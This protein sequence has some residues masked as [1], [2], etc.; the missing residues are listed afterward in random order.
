MQL[1]TLSAPRE[2]IK[3]DVFCVLKQAVYEAV[4]AAHT[5]VIVGM[6]PGV[7]WPVRSQNR[8]NV[9]KSLHS[10]VRLLENAG[11]LLQSSRDSA[12]L[13]CIFCSTSTAHTPVWHPPLMGSITVSWRN[14]MGVALCF[15]HCVHWGGS[16]RRTCT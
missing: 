1:W 8:Q 13:Q 11:W 6:R 2:D 16:G 15:L 9:F 10:G 4:L 3:G 5:A 14:S 7:A 12:I